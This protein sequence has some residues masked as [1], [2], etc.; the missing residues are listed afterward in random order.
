MFQR[1]QLTVFV[2]SLGCQQQPAAEG[3]PPHYSQPRRHLSSA[4]SR[5]S[6]RG[7]RPAS[8]SSPL[9]LSRP[10]AEAGTPGST[11]AAGTAPDAPR[12]F[13]S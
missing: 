10:S 2:F 11:P 12:H 3:P 7:S 13:H 8:S 1:I 5:S 4:S 9:R 6:W